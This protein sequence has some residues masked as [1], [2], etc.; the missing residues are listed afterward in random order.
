MFAMSLSLPGFADDFRQE[1]GPALGLIDP[2]FNQTG[3]GNIMVFR[4]DFMRTAQETGQPRV[5]VVEFGEHGLRPHVFLV[6]IPET[7]VARDV[8]DRM[9]RGGADLTR[10]FGDFV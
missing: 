10:A 6:V 3:G 7:L 8:A 4:A 5:V 2:D 9:Q 1:P